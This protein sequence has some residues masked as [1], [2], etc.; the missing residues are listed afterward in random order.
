MFT[1]IFRFMEKNRYNA[2][3]MEALQEYWPDL[4][5]AIDLEADE[6]K[7]MQF[8]DWYMHD[9]P[10]PGQGRPVIQLYWES[11]PKLSPQERQVLQDWQNTYVS[12]FQIIEIEPGEGAWAEDIFSGEK[13]FISDEILTEHVMKWELMLL[14]KIKVLEKW[15]TSTVA[16]PE[17]P[18]FKEEIRRFVEDNFRD[19]KQENP[20]ADLPTFLRNRGH[21]L[22]QVFLKLESEEPPAQ[23][24]FTS[25]GE[26][27]LFCGAHYDVYNFTEVVNRLD[28]EE[29]FEKTAD[30]SEGLVKWGFEWLERGR[31]IGRIKDT[32]P[33][34]GLTLH[35][36]FVP[37]P[38]HES[39][40]VL[41][42]IILE[43]D[44][45]A[46]LVQGEER[47]AV[48]KEILEEVLAGLI[49]HR[50]DLIQSLETMLQDSEELLM[51]ELAEM[52]D[53]EDL[54]DLDDLEEELSPEA[55]QAVLKN[56]FDNHYR[57]WLDRPL[58]ALEGQT[59]RQ[60]AQTPEGR[61]LVEDL[62][63]VVEYT[64]AC[65]DLEYDISWIRQALKL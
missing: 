4:D 3:L 6:R 15:H 29:D 58:P 9:Y 38:G 22:Y 62:L 26:E 57:Q 42:I 14:R 41:G 30:T 16:G 17:P 60:A 35:S 65:Q 23:E 19:Y 52:E 48:G 45:L 25:S 32:L 46:L 27:L 51:E 11:R 1:K 10:I 33:P 36:F 8:M 37:E 47:L 43:P 21:L 53:L 34:E 61:P 59:P 40:R 28:Q 31:S 50:E 39:H 54:D 63:R 5:P 12:V 44:F 18:H 7:L 24:I 64:L 20:D 55:E 13:T 49:S 2:H 56:V